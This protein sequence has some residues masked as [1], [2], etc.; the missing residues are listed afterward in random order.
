MAQWDTPSLHLLPLIVHFG[1][2]VLLVASAA[3]LGNDP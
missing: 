2:T 3:A 1:I